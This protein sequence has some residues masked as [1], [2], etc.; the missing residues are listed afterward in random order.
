MVR[1]TRRIEELMV[2]ELLMLMD[3]N[4]DSLDP[5]RGIVT[6]GS[7]ARLIDFH[8]ANRASEEIT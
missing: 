7:P 1:G 4:T 6:D 3:L 5:G 8:Q 2:D